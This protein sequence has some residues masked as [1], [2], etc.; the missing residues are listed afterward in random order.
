M[1]REFLAKMY[2]I[3]DKLVSFFLGK[4]GEKTRGE[5]MKVS[6]IM[7]LKTHVENMSEIGLAIML[8]KNKL[9]MP[10]LPLC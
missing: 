1:K 7:L 10:C 4:V 5:K 3:E 2:V 9:V 6:P 8:L